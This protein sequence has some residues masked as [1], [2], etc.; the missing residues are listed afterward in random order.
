MAA[1]QK[2]ASHGTGVFFELY[3]SSMNTGATTAWAWGVS[4]L[5]DALETQQQLTST[6]IASACLASPVME[7][8]PSSSA[9]SMNVSL[10][11]SHKNLDLEE[12]RAGGYLMMRRRRS[13]I[14]RRQARSSA[15]ILGL[16]PR[17]IAT[18]RRSRPCPSTTPV[19][20]VRLP[21]RACGH[22]ERHRLAG[23]RIHD[24]VP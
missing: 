14:S 21:A 1:Q 4:R 6:P 13:R 17:S 2:S 15:L 3:G 12:L 10:S 18:P 5:I 9:L 24:C 8:E 11:P 20:R 19:R 7:S 23:S 16:E 22:R